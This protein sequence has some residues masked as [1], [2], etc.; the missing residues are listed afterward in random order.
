MCSEPGSVTTEMTADWLPTKLRSL[1]NE[2]MPEDIRWDWPI[3]KML[4]RQITNTKGGDMQWGRGAK[5]EQRCWFVQIWLEVRNY[6]CCKF[7]RPRCLKMSALFPVQYES[8]AKVWMVSNLFSSWLIKLDK[9]FNMST[10]EFDNCPAHPNTQKPSKAMKLVFLPP[11]TTMRPGHRRIGALQKVSTNQD[12]RIHYSTRQ[13]YTAFWPTS[14]NNT[15]LLQALWIQTSFGRI[16]QH[17]Q[18]H[19]YYWTRKWK[20]HHWS[21]SHRRCWISW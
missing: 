3:L 8:N 9:W 13:F 17:W 20:S 16:W 10:G 19:Y 11:N 18:H 15:K 1:L 12:D 21:H 6:H 7:A 2:F 5:I 4:A 14:K